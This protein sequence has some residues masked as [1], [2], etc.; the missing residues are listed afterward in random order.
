MTQ[1]LPVSS[2]CSTPNAP[3]PNHR[4]HQRAGST[5]SEREPATLHTLPEQTC[6]S[7]IAAAFDICRCNALRVRFTCR[8]SEEDTQAVCGGAIGLPNVPP[9]DS[10]R[11]ADSND[12]PDRLSGLSGVLPKGRGKGYGLRGEHIGGGLGASWVQNVIHSRREMPLAFSFR[13]K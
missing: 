10:A 2:Q 5:A 1:R 13:N 7:S 4:Q 3:N 12:V 6:H 11:V 9:E 8:P